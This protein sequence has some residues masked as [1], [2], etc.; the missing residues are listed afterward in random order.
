MPHQKYNISDIQK[1]VGGE[2][3]AYHDDTAVENL[4]I[5]SRKLLQA[6][7]DPRMND[8]DLMLL[9]LRD[10]PLPGDLSALDDKVLGS[11]AGLRDRQSARRAMAQTDPAAL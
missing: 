3:I 11:L 10:K 6:D 5:D 2:L 9:T 8:I 7:V 4:L 1:I